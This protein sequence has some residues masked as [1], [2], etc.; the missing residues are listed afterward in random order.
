MVVTDA[1]VI[2]AAVIQ[3]VVIQAVVHLNAVANLLVVQLAVVILAVVSL[4]VVQVAAVILAVVVT[5]LANAN[6]TNMMNAAAVNVLFLVTL[7]T[8]NVIQTAAHHAIGSVNNK[9]FNLRGHRV[10]PY[11]MTS[12]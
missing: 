5:D 2:L 1:V 4:L 7:V 3:V 11:P 6:I 12:L 9:D 10:Y 8:I